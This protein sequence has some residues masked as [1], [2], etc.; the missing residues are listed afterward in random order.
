MLYNDLARSPDVAVEVVY[1]RAVDAQR[2]WGSVT[3]EH[4][5]RCLDQ[6]GRVERVRALIRS[7]RAAD[8]VCV[9]G[10][11]YPSMAAAGLLARLRRTPLAVRFDSAEEDYLERSPARRLPIRLGVRSIHGRRAVPWT[12]GDSNARFWRRLGYDDQIAVPYG[13]PPAWEHIAPAPRDVDFVYVG[14]IDASKGIE[15]LAAAWTE[16]R[17]ESRRSLLVVG[18]PHDS[19]L[20]DPLRSFPEVSIRP[21]VAWDDLPGVFGRSRA[22]IAPSRREPYGQTLIEAAACGC[23]VVVSDRVSSRFEID[24]G[25]GD[26]LFDAGDADDLLRALRRVESGFGAVTDS[27]ASR[28]VPRSSSDDLV[29][30]TLLMLRR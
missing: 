2:G 24:L 5:H 23:A 13:V 21:A 10:W 30:A 12:I 25:D 4:E 9:H 7:V 26:A 27:T 1:R 18:R 8:V 15:E 11:R 28:R 16:F 19:H 6:L 22:A 20:L 14:R 17:R 3:I 29:A